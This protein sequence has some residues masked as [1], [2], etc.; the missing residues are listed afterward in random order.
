MPRTHGLVLALTRCNSAARGAEWEEWYDQEHLPDLVRDGG[1]WVATRWRLPDPPVPGRPSLGF[2]HAALYELDD[3]D[4]DGAARRLLA[5]ERARRRRRGGPPA[6][7]GRGVA[8]LSAARDRALRRRGRVHP[9]HCVIGV[10]LLRAH[11]KW[12]DKA[13]P[14]ASLRGHILAWV[15]C[16]D[17][18]REAEWDAWY[19]AQHAPD[20]LECGA[21]SAITRWQ[22]RRRSAFGP[23]HLTL[24]DVSGASVA[25]AVERSFAI[26]PRI[27][28]A[29]RWLDC[30]AGGMAFTLEPAG[31]YGAA[32]VRR[33]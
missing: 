2:T 11:G 28:G 8:Q 33:P 18:G 22:R 32:G 31:C 16:N 19:D 26:M 6:P 17:P 3:P 9:A 13:P 20:M 30:H 24:Y 4:L 7:S 27:H 21:F 25:E 12:S 10:E 23:Q 29:G 5:R 1:P 15:M 14:S